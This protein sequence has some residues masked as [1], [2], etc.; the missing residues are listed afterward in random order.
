MRMSKCSR[1]IL[2]SLNHAARTFDLV[3][4]CECPPMERT[5]TRL[6]QR[7]F[8][9]GEI[10]ANQPFGQKVEQRAK[11][12]ARLFLG[13]Y[14][15]IEEANHPRVEA[16]DSQRE[17]FRTQFGI[18]HGVDNGNLR[19]AAERCGLSIPV[20]VAAVGHHEQQ[21]DRRFPGSLAPTAQHPMCVIPC[22]FC[23]CARCEAHNDAGVLNVDTGYFHVRH[24]SN[25]WGCRERLTLVPAL[26]Y[27][28]IERAVEPGGSG[29]KRLS[30]PL[31]RFVHPT[32]QSVPPT[33]T[34]V[35]TIRFENGWAGHRGWALDA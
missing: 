18:G 12:R 30:Q 4:G 31:M 25:S 20:R 17:L 2:V 7:R 22:A 13:G 10:R 1:E 3:I 8:E 9:V 23:R 27:A 33:T 14:N 28:S 34:L 15:N 21:V 6:T 32:F 16:R 29:Y 19:F 35:L 11:H 26:V 24:S 5:R